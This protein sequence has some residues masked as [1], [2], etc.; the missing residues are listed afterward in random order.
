MA[1]SSL[2]D[3]K[4]KDIDGVESSGASLFANKVVLVTNVASRCG[5]TKK[6]YEYMYDLLS[7]SLGSGDAPNMSIQEDERGNILVK[8]LIQKVVFL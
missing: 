5:K 6:H 8:G 4:L 2:H 7:P 3:F 1:T